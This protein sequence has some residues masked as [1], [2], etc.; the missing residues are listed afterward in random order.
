MK[1]Y[2]QIPVAPKDKEKIVFAFAT[3]KGFY[4]FVKMPFRLHGT[5]TSFQRVMDKALD[6][7]WDYTY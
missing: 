1:G 4:H 7:V 3:P 5:A 6:P 2:W